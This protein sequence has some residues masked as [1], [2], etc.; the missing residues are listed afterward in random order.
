MKRLICLFFGL[1]LLSACGHT[2]RMMDPYE[3]KLNV[4]KDAS[5][6]ELIS[7]LGEPQKFYDAGGS[8]FLLYFYQNSYMAPR[9]QRSF[10]TDRGAFAPAA[11]DY[12][13]TEFCSLTF[14]VQ[15]GLVKSWKYQGTCR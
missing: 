8:R 3:A 5:E 14:I 15:D 12:A 7:V 1:S 13:V 9:E 6:A 2:A 10:Y 4:F 11:T